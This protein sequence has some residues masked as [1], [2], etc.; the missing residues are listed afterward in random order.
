MRAVT[1]PVTASGLTEVMSKADRIQCSVRS[2][3]A[4]DCLSDILT[5][6][7]GYVSLVRQLEQCEQKYLLAVLDISDPEHSI[8][9]TSSRQC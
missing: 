4:T 6:S 5:V 7:V 8:A 9:E 3:Y 1:T 2:F